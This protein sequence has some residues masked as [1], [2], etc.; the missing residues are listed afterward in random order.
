LE[1]SSYTSKRPDKDGQELADIALIGCAERQDQTY[2]YRNAGDQ[3]PS[4]WAEHANSWDDVAHG[5]L[6]VELSGAH[7]DVWA[8]HFIPHAPASAKC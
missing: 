5:A 7:A 2:D 3:P 8:W 6:T 4:P 1:L